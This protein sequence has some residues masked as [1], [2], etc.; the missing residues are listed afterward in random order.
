MGIRFNGGLIVKILAWA[1]SVLDEIIQ[2]KR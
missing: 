1:F 2:R